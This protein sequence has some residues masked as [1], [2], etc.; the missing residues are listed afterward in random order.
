MK[1]IVKILV[2]LTLLASSSWAQFSSLRT[3]TTFQRDRVS[4]G[5]SVNRF[6]AGGVVNIK[7]DLK[8][9]LLGRKVVDDVLGI[10]AP[11]VIE[12]NG[13]FLTPG[14]IKLGDWKK[15]DE[16]IG[17]LQITKDFNDLRLSLELGAGFR[18][19]SA[20]RN[21]AVLRVS[22]DLFTLEG[23]FLSRYGYKTINELT[24]KK[25]YWLA[26]HPNDFFVSVGSEVDR[27]W[28]LTG[29]KG[30]NS[31]G[32]LTLLNVDRTNKNFWFRSQTGFGEI[33]QK[34]FCQDL[35]ILATS[36][37]VVPPFFYLHFS[38]ISTKGTYAFKV[39]GRRTGEY[40]KW[41]VIGA[42]QLGSIGQVALGWQTDINKENGVVVEYYNSFPLSDVFNLSLELKYE[43]ITNCLSGFLT[44]NYEI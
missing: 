20:P 33:N 8:R 21:F 25:F 31:F 15:S 36:Y 4:K 35:Y 38:P 44:S 3:E 40:E 28:I 39:D 30:L 6:Q 29:T 17:D 32:N 11:N 5:I 10:F 42:H 12:S 18:S 14:I 37:L 41:E 23:S 9:D 16:V 13:Y 1:E 43:K 26:F 24:D 19:T 2:L 34:F 7:Y 22:Q 27:T